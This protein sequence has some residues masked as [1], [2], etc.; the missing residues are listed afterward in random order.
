[1]LTR[2]GF[3]GALLLVVALLGAAP[4][5]AQVSMSA[6]ATAATVHYDGFLRSGVFL[7][8][9]IVRVDRPQFSVTGRGT[10]SRF[11]SGNHSTDLVL[12]GSVFTPRL[13]EWQAELTADGGISRYLQNNTGYGSLG[14]R[15]HRAGPRT[16]TWL[17]ISRVSVTGGAD[18]IGST[19][20]E[21]G[22]W[23]R[24]G[25]LAFSAAATG[26]AM[27]D[28][29]YF[30][31]GVHARWDHA[32]LQL[33]ASAGAR[34]G[35][36]TGGAR[37]WGDLSAT[38][39]LSRRIA[40]VIGH[41]AY[42]VD[43]A[44]LAPGGRYTALSMRIATR[45]PALRDA[46]ARTIRNPTPANIRPVV[47]TFDVKRNRD[48]T[49]RLRVRAPGASSVEL[50]GDFSDWDPLSLERTVGDSWQIVLPLATGTHRINIRVDGGEWG[51]PPGIGTLRDEFGDVVGVLLIA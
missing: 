48:G 45:P 27:R 24:T 42:P 18:L 39:W 30:D 8:T 9:P 19:R 43:L 21:L 15:L 40:M 50:M 36:E 46:L 32:W 12:A 1:V 33:T 47:A 23:A 37:R 35:D 17:G 5:R 22:T 11:E 3:G 7:F 31:A 20:G 44:Q 6:D 16:G 38:M 49:V 51:V 25:E 14:A 34:A 4:A 26:T 13:E 28:V 2:P 29:S 41:G 10:F